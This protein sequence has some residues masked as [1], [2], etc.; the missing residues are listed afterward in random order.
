MAEIQETWMPRV[1][2]PHFRLLTSLVV[3]ALA[4][5][6]S[7]WLPHIG[8]RIVLAW[9]SGVT[10]LLA[11]IAIMMWR[12]DPNETLRRARK[13]EATNI[14]IILVTILAVAGALVAIAD[15]LP[16][17]ESMSPALRVFYIC[18]SVVGVILAW[19]LTHVMY[20]L[21]YA[22]LYYG[23]IGPTDAN[24]FR[25]GLTFPGNSDVVDYWDFVYYSFTIAMCFQTSD[26]TV[27]SPYMRRLTIFHATVSYF[28]ALAILGLLLNGFIS[29][30]S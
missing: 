20:S 1:L 15:G 18:E 8:S 10:V 12:S 13:E 3:A 23:E 11:L 19:L 30:L 24:G 26:V 27:T 17:G 16:R 2:R 22:K 25:K 28:F 6:L 29:N 21:H 4:F 14:V 5:R 9:D 7:S